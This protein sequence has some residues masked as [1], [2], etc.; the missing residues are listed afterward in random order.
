MTAR[1]AL[2]LAGLSMACVDRAA[3]VQRPGPPPAAASS[4]APR[5]A[6]ADEADREP[7]LDEGP[8]R[9]IVAARFRD[10]GLRVVED[11]ALTAP[12]AIT[13]DGFDPERRIGFE[14]VAPEEARDL[15]AIDRAALVRSTDPR[16]LV[17]APC[18]EARCTRVADEFLRALPPAPPAGGTR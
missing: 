9:R 6:A 10:A 5:P 11:V 16:V 2:L 14:Y 1:A 13:L 12:V 18:G 4:R 8:A 3:D 17:L 15:A 7:P